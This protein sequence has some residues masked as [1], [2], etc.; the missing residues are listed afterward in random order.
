MILSFVQ[1]RTVSACLRASFLAIFCTA[2]PLYAAGL[3]QLESM[4]QSVFALDSARQTALDEI[5]RATLS[6]E[7]RDDYK[8]FIVYLNTRIV[9]YCMELAEQGGATAVE[10]LP[11]PDLPISGNT[12]SEQAATEETFIYLPVSEPQE[13]HT[14]AEKTASMDKQ[15]F[16]ALGEF[17]E[18][19]LKEEEK[20]SSRV[21][22]QRESGGSGRAGTS[23]SSGDSAETG[24]SGD[25]TGDQAGSGTTSADAG[26]IGSS[27]VQSGQATGDG[28]TPG[29]QSN[30]GAG[31]GAGDADIDHSAY[32][33]PGGKLPP[34]QDDD[35]V[36]RQLREAAEK[37]TDPELKK[38]LWEE[39]WKYKGV[40][41]GE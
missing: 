6:R 26:E 32:G 20:V 35:I 37:E 23:G 4:R 22:S 31:A 34:P 12:A 3:D 2:S 36:A 14:R 29:T 8:D 21:P 18:L 15:L 33:A 28:T 13:T 16:A 40:K 5:G 1:A 25:G 9:N 30:V 17:D 41:K 24:E 19:L 38:K 27:S 7:E 39:Y 11:C 10:G